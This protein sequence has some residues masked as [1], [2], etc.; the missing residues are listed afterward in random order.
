LELNKFLIGFCTQNNL[1]TRKKV[2]AGKEITMACLQISW[3]LQ[4]ILKICQRINR[5]SVI[6]ATR[7]Q[8][9]GKGK[10]DTEKYVQS[11]RRVCMKS[12][13]LSIGVL[14]AVRILQKSTVYLNLLWGKIY[15]FHI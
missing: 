7:E 10:E 12:A 2:A 9:M 1:I 5:K 3:P 8:N 11:M 15:N 14:S 13:Y 4:S 6:C